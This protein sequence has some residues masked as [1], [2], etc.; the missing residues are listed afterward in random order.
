MFKLKV[1]SLQCFKL[2]IQRKTYSNLGSSFE[3]SSSFRNT[4][5]VNFLQPSLFN[6]KQLS[7]SRSFSTEAKSEA[8][9]E[10]KDEKNDE[11]PEKKKVQ[12][13][14]EK[15]QTANFMNEKQAL[16]TEFDS[17]IHIRDEDSPPGP[18]VE[19]LIEET[20]Q[21][22]IVE[23]FLLMKGMSKKL[24]IPL[25]TIFASGGGG[26]SAPAT[27]GTADA[28]QA[29]AKQTEAK[30]E[31]ST[32][33]VK[34]TQLDEGSKYKVLKEF[35][36]IKPG[37]SLTETKKLLENLPK[38]LIEGVSKEEAQKIVDKLR[39]NGATAEVE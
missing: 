38:I 18:K 14:N 3:R 21:L 22:N 13:Q 27:P 5:K 24:G 35:R 4:S 15:T 36:N 6:F 28:N 10:K 2:S 34:L 16:Q 29:T 8:N 31:K 17:L 19:R 32:F 30:K 12:N 1:T 9:P 33:S 11:K 39:E 7:Y 26:S 20:S 23:L 25:E 37:L